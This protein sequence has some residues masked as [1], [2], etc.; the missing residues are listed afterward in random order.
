MSGA[1]SARARDT[2]SLDQAPELV[3]VEVLAVDGGRSNVRRLAQLHVRT[4]GRLRVLRTA[5]LGGPV[6]VEIR[7]S[8][9]ALGRALAR[10]VTV[11]LLP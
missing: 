11:R 1:P 3:W 6:L 5:P 4:G 8:A 10:Q 9:I 2:L 7:D